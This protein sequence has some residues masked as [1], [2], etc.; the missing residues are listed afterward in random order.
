MRSTSS[1]E[2][3]HARQHQ[4]GVQRGEGGLE[5]GDAHRRQLE[6]LLLLL[7]RVRGVV[8]GDAVDRARAQRLDQRLAVG[9]GPQRRVHLEVRVERP[10]RL[11]GEQQVVRRGLAGHLRARRLA[12]ARSPRPSR[13]RTRAAR[14][15]GPPRRR[16]SAQSRATIVDSD[17]DGIPARPSSADTSPSCIA[18]SPDSEGSSSCSASSRPASRWYWSAWRITPAERTGQPVVG[19]A[20]RAG[21]RRARPSRSAARP[22]GPR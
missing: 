7:A 8:G 2:L 6:R 17:T 14:G 9:L 5:P 22:A 13:A 3:E 16:A 4:A 21:R 20:G 12:R 11:V 19:E 15:C 1:A 10:H 18:P